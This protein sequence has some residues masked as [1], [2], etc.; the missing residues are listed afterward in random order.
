MLA[1]ALIFLMGIGNFAAHQAVLH[2]GHPLLG[3]VPWFVH[4]L[5]G[6]IGLASEFLILLAAMLLSADGSAVPGWIYA[7]YTAFNLGA[8]WMIVTRRI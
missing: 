3:E 2:S 6:K 4:L 8:A 1:L 7:L 5:G